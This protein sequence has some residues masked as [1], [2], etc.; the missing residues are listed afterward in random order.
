MPREKTHIKPIR[1]VHVL[2]LLLAIAGVY[3]VAIQLG[4]VQKTLGLFMQSL[5]LWAM[6]AVIATIA[7]LLCAAWCSIWP[8]IKSVAHTNCSY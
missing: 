1:S 8:V 7:A 3:Y 4:D 6:G 2:F 5:W